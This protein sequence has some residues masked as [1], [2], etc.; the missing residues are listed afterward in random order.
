MGRTPQY[1]CACVLDT[2]PTQQDCQCCKFV[3][4]TESEVASYILKGLSDKHLVRLFLDRAF[5]AT[6][7]LKQN[8]NCQAFEK[9]AKHIQQYS[10]Y[11]VGTPHAFW[12]KGGI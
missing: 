11:H 2:H 3:Q 8:N 4:T 1:Y 12:N 9:K 6:P 7:S 10:S 5:L